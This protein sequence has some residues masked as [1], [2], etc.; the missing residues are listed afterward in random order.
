MSSIA[1]LIDRLDPAP[2][3]WAA[4][5]ALAAAFGAALDNPG[6][7]AVCVVGESRAW[8]LQPEGGAVLPILPVRGNPVYGGLSDEQLDPALRGLRLAAGVRARRA[9]TSTPGRCWS[10]ASRWSSAAHPLPPR[11]ALTLPEP[12]GVRVDAPGAE[13]RGGLGRAPT[14][15]TSPPPIPAAS[16]SSTTTA[17][18]SAEYIATGRHGVARDR[19]AGDHR[20][21]CRPTA[22]PPLAGDAHVLLPADANTLLATL[23]RCLDHVADRRLRAPAPAVPDARSRRGSTSR[24]APRRGSGR[25]ATVSRTRDRR[26]RRHPDRRG[27]GRGGA[28]ARARARAAGALRQ[29]QRPLR[30]GRAARGLSQGAVQRDLHQGAPGACSPSTATP[31]RSTGSPTGV[32]SRRA[33]TCARPRAR[34]LLAGDRGAHRAP[35]SSRRD[36]AEHVGRVRDPGRPGGRAGDRRAPGGCARRSARRR[37]PFTLALRRRRRSEPPIVM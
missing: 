35:T 33:S 16:G 21:C 37:R 20:C 31:R 26:L 24:A 34:P 32:R 9:S 36:A 10:R 8:H 29:R 3:W 19:P 2:S 18:G 12:D 14:S 7:V 15:P 6:V 25:P 1:A 4:R 11:G 27:A 13:P 17:A 23:E 30:A 22:C 28:A 5:T